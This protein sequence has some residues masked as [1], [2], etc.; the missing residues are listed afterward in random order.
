MFLQEPEERGRASVCRF[1]QLSFIIVRVLTAPIASCIGARS[2]ASMLGGG[3]LDGCALDF[4]QPQERCLNLPLRDLYSVICDSAL[5]PTEHQ[6]PAEYPPVGTR[7][8]D[9]DSTI[10]DVCD[11]IVEYIDSDVLGLLSDRHLILAGE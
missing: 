3:D 4:S 7:K 9:R 8:L 6:E 11:F 1:V 10:E 5:L 2:L